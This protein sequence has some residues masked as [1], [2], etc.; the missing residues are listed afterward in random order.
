MNARYIDVAQSEWAAALLDPALPKP[1]GL[2]CWN[3][4]DPK[5][6][7]DVYR[8]NVVSTLVDSLAA[9]FPVT[10]QL[11]GEEFFRAMAAEYVRRQPPQNPILAHYGDAL[12]AFIAT[13]PPAGPVPYLA[14][15]A[16]LE[17]ARIRAY[18]AADD[19]VL[20]GEVMVPLVARS[21]T[22][23][24]LYFRMHPAA[25]LVSS[26]H[27]FVSLWAAH[28]QPEVDLT[29]IDLREP[30]HALVTRAGQD[31]HVVAVD[32]PTAAFIVAIFLGRSLQDAAERSFGT[33]SRRSLLDALV[34]LLRNGAVSEMSGSEFWTS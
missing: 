30:E 6:R 28:Q 10:L 17:A 7:F 34:L 32:A 12:P 5:R 31:V 1:A 19:A 13:F 11:V 33:G 16:R 8:N 27:A 15:V 9:S 18:Y 14:D 4:S 29:G 24:R 25:A 20:T 2:R 23:N 21:L 22:L 26:P 3:G